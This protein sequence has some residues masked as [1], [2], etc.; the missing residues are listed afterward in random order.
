MKQIKYFKIFASLI[1]TIV[2][3]GAFLV[4]NHP[5]AEDTYQRTDDAYV[6]ADFTIIAPQVSGVISHVYVL[7]NQHVKVGEPLVSIDDDEFRIAVDRAKA[8]IASAKAVIESLRAQRSR[9][10]SVIQQARAAVAA[11]EAQLKLADSEKQRYV[12]LA[13]DGSGS[14]QARQQAE[15]QWNVQKAAVERDYAALRSAMQ[16]TSIIN[17]DI[18]KAV[19]SLTAAQARQSEAELNLSRTNILAPVAGIVT[20]RRAREGGYARTGDPLMTLVPLDALYVEANYRETQVEKMRPGQPVQLTV[21][22]LPGVV[23]KGKI[24]SMGPASGVSF[25]AVPPHNATGNFTKI[26]QRMPVRI[27]LDH[28][29]YALQQLRVG[30]SVSPRV[31]TGNF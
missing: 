17:A 19:A 7:E 16:Q 18:E 28:N 4:L 21:D 9:Q 11:S 23:L 1:L 13:K 3:I 20:Q 22:A 10:D 6:R 25:S 8:E 2:I 12:N 14:V 5:E 29:Q 24:E 27:S 26:V 30:M 15:A 31:T